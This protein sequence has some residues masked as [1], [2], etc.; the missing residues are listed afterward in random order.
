MLSLG[1]P[2]VIADRYTK[3]WPPLE[4]GDLIELKSE[5][6]DSLGTALC[7]PGSRIVARRLSE[8]IVELDQDWLTVQLQRAQ[9]SRN[10]LDFGDTTVARLVNAEG[11]GLPGLTVDRYGDFLMVQY[12]TSA[13]QKHLSSLAVALQEVCAPLGI[14]CKYRP[15]E[16]RKLA[17]GKKQR[18]PQGRL[19]AGKAAPVDLTVRENG[20]LYRIDLVKDLHTGLFHDQRNNRLEFRR[21]A[22]GCR[23]LNLFA[24]TGA[25]SVAAAAGGAE[26]VTSIDVAGRYLDWARENFRLNGMVPE[27]HEFITG[28][29]SF[30]LDRLARSGRRFDIVL[31]DPPSF[32]TTRKSRFATSGGT[33]ELVQKALRLIAPDGLLVT[34][35]NLQ[36]MSLADYL[37]ELRKG[38]IAA[39]RHLQVVKVAGQADDFPFTVSF[40]EGNYL[41]YVVS[42]VRDK[43]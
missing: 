31:M 29:C 8:K 12:Y 2:W 10:W 42:V 35:S 13:W 16:T 14:Y 32:S 18:P 23:V 15:Q 36:K 26:R 40:P 39:D 5:K 43:D 3:S 34:S 41:K 24:Y 20:L 21:L 30:E 33:A 9:A 19:L 27:D 28:D 1:H 7:A 6:G 37:K 38:S 25:F 4:C 11:D 17:A 22:A